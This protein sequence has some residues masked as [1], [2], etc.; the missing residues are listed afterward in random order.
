MLYEV[1]TTFHFAKARFAVFYDD[2]LIFASSQKAMQEYLADM[3][4]N[5]SLD[6]D[7][8]YSD[9]IRASDSRANIS[10]Y[11]SINRLLP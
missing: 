8:A 9:F 11:A 6:N 4:L 5:Y 10:A 3:E 1:I 7:R 2:Y